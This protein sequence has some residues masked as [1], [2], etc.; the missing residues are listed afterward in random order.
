LIDASGA[1]GSCRSIFG[2]N[3]HVNHSGLCSHLIYAYNLWFKELINN[4]E[5]KISNKIQHSLYLLQQKT[6][7]SFLKETKVCPNC[8][9]TVTTIQEQNDLF[10]TRIVSGKVIPQSWCKK[11]RAKY[12]NNLN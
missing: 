5:T 1:L 9:L 2:K 8:S 4:D 6:N 10:G 11:C 7:S 3:C 12:K